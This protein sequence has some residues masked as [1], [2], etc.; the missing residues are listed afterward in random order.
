VTPL[1][2]LFAISSAGSLFTLWAIT[3]ALLDLHRAYAS[4]ANG[5]R[6]IAA[7]M[8]LMLHSTLLVGYGLWFWLCID[9]LRAGT[10]S[11]W[12]VAVA[13]LIAAETAFGLVSLGLRLM[14]VRLDRYRRDV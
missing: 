14:R 12:S 2:A 11:E 8:F 3:D 9:A 4:R 7:Q 1:Q 5:L 10:A 13:R 6:R